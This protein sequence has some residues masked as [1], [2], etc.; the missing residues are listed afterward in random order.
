LSPVFEFDTGASE[1]NR[2]KT[3]MEKNIEALMKK[4]AD[5][6]HRK[7]PKS[8]FVKDGAFPCYEDQQTKILFIGRELYGKKNDG[9][10][11]VINYW[12]ERAGMDNL[13]VFQSRL[14][15]LA[16]GISKGQCT[17]AHWKKMQCAAELDCRFATEEF[18]YAFM[19]ASKLLNVDGTQIGDVFYDFINDKTNQDF[20]IREIELLNPDIIVSGN[21]GDIGFMAKLEESCKV[22]Q[23]AKHLNSQN[24]F[25]YL[26]EGKISWIDTWHFSAHKAHFEGFYQPVC[27]AAAI[28]LGKEQGTT[29]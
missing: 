14:L 19:N 16:Y 13:G 4:W 15:Y 7:W 28:F 8:I 10:G 18:S 22:K 25:N 9:D 23:S 12:D 24:R 20:F 17:E 3:E 1:G 29:D 27:E 2:M 5:Y 21:L 11:L 26:F 6:C